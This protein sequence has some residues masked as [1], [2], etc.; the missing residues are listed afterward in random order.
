ML[1]F[2]LTQY[3]V[4]GRTQDE[5]F[6]QWSRG[7]TLRGNENELVRKNFFSL[8]SSV[9]LIKISISYRAGWLS[10]MQLRI[11]TLSKS[12][13]LIRNTTWQER[14]ITTKHFYNKSTIKR[15]QFKRLQKDHK[16]TVA[17]NQMN[18]TENYL[19]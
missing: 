5:F 8:L 7:I 10:I 9:V 13:M 2:F 12:Y 15:R 17:K 11:I 6:L 3:L 1:G 19:F 14:E 18:R 4:P 16:R